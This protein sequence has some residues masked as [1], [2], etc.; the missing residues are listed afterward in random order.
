MQPASANPSACIGEGPAADALSSVILV[1]PDDPVRTRSCSQT[2]STT[3]GGFMR[4]FYS[5]LGSQLRALGQIIER[6]V[7]GLPESLKPEA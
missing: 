2:R 4:T 1:A 3:V 5:A 7:R 6:V